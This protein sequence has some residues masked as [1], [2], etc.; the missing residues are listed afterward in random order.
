MA[1]LFDDEIKQEKE[2]AASYF[3]GKIMNT[4]LLKTLDEYIEDY[5]GA[6]AK[7]F[8]LNPWQYYFHKVKGLHKRLIPKITEQQLATILV[9]I[10][11]YR[12]DTN[13]IIM[14]EV[15]ED[16]NKGLYDTL[17]NDEEVEQESNEIDNQ[18]NDEE[19]ESWGDVEDTIDWGDL[20]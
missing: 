6:E 19:Q 12:K 4:G 3:V 11:H 18:E 20:E 2:N 5:Y 10:A 8:G 1:R 17:F 14:E 15:L 9:I 7:R 16:Y 13:L